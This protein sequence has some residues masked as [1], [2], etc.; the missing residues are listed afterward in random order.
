LVLPFVRLATLFSFVRRCSGPGPTAFTVGRP[1]QVIIVTVTNFIS[2]PRSRTDLRALDSHKKVRALKP[3][4]SHLLDSSPPEPSSPFSLHGDSPWHP[5]ADLI[6]SRGGTKGSGL[7][8][9]CGRAERRLSK[10]L[11]AANACRGAS[12]TWLTMCSRMG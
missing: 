12:W 6:P 11:A 3:L 4:P 7:R 2:C 9:G 1:V 10:R 5:A 8:R